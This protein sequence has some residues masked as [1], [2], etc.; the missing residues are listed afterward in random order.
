MDN[1]LRTAIVGTAQVTGNIELTTGTQVDMLSGQLPSGQRERNILL[2]AGALEV[3]RL[4]GQRT[5]KRAD[6]LEQALLGQST[7]TRSR[8]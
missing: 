4:A 5:Q 1:L 2:S 3:Y 8:T 7:R 6:Q